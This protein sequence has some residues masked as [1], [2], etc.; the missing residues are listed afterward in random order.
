MSCGNQ[1]F[2]IQQG[3]TFRQVIRWEAPPIIYKPI[4][5]ISQSGPVSITVADTSDL[6]PDWRV[7]VT[8]VRGMKEINDLAG[9]ATV[10]NGTTV[11]INTINSSLFSAYTSGGYL[12]Y[13]T[14]VVLTGMT[15][16]MSIKDKVGGTELLSLTT[17]NGGITVS[18]ST[19]KITLLISDTDTAAIT[20]QRGVY[21]LEIIDLSGSV[22]QLLQGKI[23]VQREVTV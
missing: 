17:E 1:D 4:T 6:P 5:A 14:P 7:K 11:E 20:W 16:R 19:K 9:L 23:T 15:A 12:E 2:V 13:N 10:V 18:N 8:S 3:K 22:I 21:D